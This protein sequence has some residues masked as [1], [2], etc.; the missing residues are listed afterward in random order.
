MPEVPDK[1]T[2]L[3]VYAPNEL[4][5][6]EASFLA[7]VLA[8]LSD[9]YLLADVSVEFADISHG[10]PI[11]FEEQGGTL[12]LWIARDGSSVKPVVMSYYTAYEVFGGFVKDYVR[13]HIYP[14]ITKYVPSSTREGVRRAAPACSKRTASYTGTR[15]ASWVTSS[16]CLGNTW[17]ARSHSR[18]SSLL[19]RTPDA[20]R[21]RSSEKNRWVASKMRS[22]TW[23]SRRKILN[24]RSTSNL[25][26][27]RR[28]CGR[29][30]FPPSRF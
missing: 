16:R 9:D 5:R 29:T 23:P 10:V 21:P 12:R 2:V 26:P 17:R 28:S 13:N 14:Q 27:R 22:R 19:P 30:W 20:H 1:T 7:R 4:L 3:K 15:K 8:T 25:K 18:R 6:E 11:K 24:P